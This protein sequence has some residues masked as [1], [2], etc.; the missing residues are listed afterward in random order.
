[1]REFAFGAWEGL[2]WEE[3]VASDARVR[4]L[5]PTAAAEYTP[6][7]GETFGEVAARVGAF[8]EELRARPHRRIVAVTHAGPLHA[9]L[10]A[11]ELSDEAPRVS[12]SPGGV[13]RLA[14][15]D[16]GARLISL[17]DV[18]HLHPAG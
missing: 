1:M 6:E 14:M 5:A 16:D 4:D 9:A 15:T 11:L 12:F 2:T 8:F 7:G 3:I 13:T 17:N 18:R 10:A